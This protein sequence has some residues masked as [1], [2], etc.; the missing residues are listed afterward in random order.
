MYVY[1]IIYYHYSITATTSIT[2]TLSTNTSNTNTTNTH[3]RVLSLIS[4]QKSKAGKPYH[5][6]NVAIK[7]ITVTTSL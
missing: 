4:D 6:P 3:F 7:T 5:F 2:T 1:I